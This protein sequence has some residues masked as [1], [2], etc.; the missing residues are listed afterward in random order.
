MTVRTRKQIDS[1]LKTLDSRLNDFQQVLPRLDPRHS[2]LDV[3][4]LVLKQIFGTAT[5]SDVHMIHEVLDELQQRNSDI[6][7]SVSNQLSYVKDLGNVNAEAIANMSS[8]VKEQ[9]IQQ[10]D[11]L[12]QCSTPY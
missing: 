7:H 2:L 5:V 9:M 6:A 3:G 4:G 8:V 11:G 10:I 12:M 1:L